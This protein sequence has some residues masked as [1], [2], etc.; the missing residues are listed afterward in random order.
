VF[1]CKEELLP[2]MSQPTG[3]IKIG[4][5]LSGAVVRGFVHIGVL[6]ALEEENIRPDMIGGSSAGSIIAYLSAAGLS[7]QQI[8]DLSQQISW[9]RMI[10]PIFSRTGFVS[11]EPIEKLLIRFVGDLH[12]EDLAIP[13]VVS[14]TDLAT[15]EP[16]LFSQGAIAPAVHASC[17]VP[18]FAR[19]VSHGGY[20]S[21]IDGGVSN[22]TPSDSVRALGADFVIAVD[23]FAPHRRR[24][25]GP[26]RVGLNA[27][28]IMVRN[29]NRG[30]KQADCLIAPDLSDVSFYRFGQKQRMIDIGRRETEKHLD[31]IKQG[32]SQGSTID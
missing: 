19:P 7:S 2:I 5:A 13:L 21:L 6:Q 31:E 3:K 27:I 12:F 22:N 14:T 26:I 15:G 28:E 8:L 30:P 10:R 29:S 32:L 17:A 4:L 9:L 25:G 23:A 24:F 1:L 20:H 16:V 11:F 18:G